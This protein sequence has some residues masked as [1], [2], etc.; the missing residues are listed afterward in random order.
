MTTIIAGVFVI[1]ERTG[2]AN[3]NPFENQVTDTPMTALCNTIER[4]L[5]EMLGY[6]ELPKKIEPKDG[7]LF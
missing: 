1:M 7:Y 3:E 2:A 6:A 4:D 5:K